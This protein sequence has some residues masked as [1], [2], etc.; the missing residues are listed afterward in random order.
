MT[1]SAINAHV[2]SSAAADCQC[3][4]KRQTTA[5]ERTAVASSMTG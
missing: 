3:Q 4:P 5:I 1:V 2:K